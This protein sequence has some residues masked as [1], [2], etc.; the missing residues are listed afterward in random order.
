MFSD[1]VVAYLFLGGT[2]AGC[3]LVASVLALLSDPDELDDALSCR[4][5]SDQGTLWKRF[6]AAM[7]L[8]GLSALLLGAICLLADVGRPDRL[9]SLLF[10]PAP[11]FVAFGA[12]SIVLCMAFSALCVLLWMGAVPSTRRQMVAACAVDAV[13]AVAVVIY[14]GLLLSDVQAVPLWNTPWLVALFA[15]SAA[16]CGIALA[17][18]AAF[19]SR[20]MSAFASTLVGLAKA[21]AAVIAVE[22]VV[23]VFC[24]LSVWGAAGGAAGPS[25]GTDQAALESLGSLL[26][27]PWAVLFWAGFAVVGLAVPFVHDV[28]IGRSARAAASVARTAPS[29]LFVL[30]TAGCVLV[31]GFVLRLMVVG[32]GIHPAASFAF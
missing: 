19:A 28:I 20:T 22:A 16:S 3:C 9:M 30:G 29:T 17:L 23:G 25:D 11:T 18:V 10:Q 6:F 1:L 26:A 5:L 14:T 7:Y 8:A 15:L 12:W 31:G 27:G 4:M 24:L 13:A 21:D 32:A 2:G